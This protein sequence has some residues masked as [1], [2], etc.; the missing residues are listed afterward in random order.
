MVDEQ[1]DVVSSNRLRLVLLTAGMM[2]SLLEG[3]REPVESAIG[4]SIPRD[5]P[6]ERS[7]GL[8]RLRIDQ[9]DKDPGSAP[10]LL[11]LMVE[12]VEERV[13]GHIGFHG[14][15]DDRGVVEIGYRVFDRWQRRGYATEAVK[16]LFGWARTEK[17]V[18]RFR[19]SI[20]PWNGPSLRMSERLGFKKVGVQWDDIDG[21]EIV[22]EMDAAPNDART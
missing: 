2:K 20:G 3:D 12:T 8:L 21:E 16:A 4:A 13:I 18:S 9:I 1:L 15:P 5:W 10:W 14:S 7:V 11:R 6:S 19:A 17:G 22:F